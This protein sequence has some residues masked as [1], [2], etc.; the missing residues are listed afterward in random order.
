MSHF[1]DMQGNPLTLE[2]WSKRFN[3]P[4]RIIAQQTIGDYWISTVWL[5]LDHSHHYGPPLI[6]ETMVFDADRSSGYEHRM[7]RYTTLEEA[8]AGHAR[9]AAVLKRLQRLKAAAA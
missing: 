3:D 2:Q 8:K 9:L 4:E 5:G 1:Y 7:V 6:F